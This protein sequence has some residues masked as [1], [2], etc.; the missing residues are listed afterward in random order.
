MSQ[1]LDWTFSGSPIL[2]V[3]LTIAMLAGFSVIEV[4]AS[5][6]RRDRRR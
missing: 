1:I 6:R 2:A 4:I 5:R 3:T